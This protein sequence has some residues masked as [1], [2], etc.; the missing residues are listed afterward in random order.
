MKLQ[1]FTKEEML[2]LEQVKNLKEDDDDSVARKIREWSRAYKV[3]KML[4]KTQILELY[5]N[6]GYKIPYL[7]ITFWFF[8]F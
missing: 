3:E 5:L 1:H 6:E 8:I 2:I 7:P 4:S